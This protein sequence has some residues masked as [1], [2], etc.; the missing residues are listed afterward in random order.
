MTDYLFESQTDYVYQNQTK[1]K[2]DIHCKENNIRKVEVE[3]KKGKEPVDDVP[4][5]EG[6]NIDHVPLKF[7]QV[8]YI[9]LHDKEEILGKRKRSTK[10]STKTSTSM[11]Q[12]IKTKQ[13]KPTSKG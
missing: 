10:V 6:D 2:E 9:V 11:I 4:A 3:K 12:E 8:E 5:N 7:R 1:K 13:R